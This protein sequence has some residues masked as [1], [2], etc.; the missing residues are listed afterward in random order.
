MTAVPF[1]FIFAGGLD[2]ETPT[3]NK[4]PG[5]AI[6]CLNHE[7]SSTGYK[8]IQGFERVSGRPS[9]AAYDLL[10]GEFE[11][12]AA[13]LKN[14]TIVGLTSGATAYVVDVKTLSGSTGAG[15]AAGLFC[16]DDVTGE[17]SVGEYLMVN[18][19]AIAR[20]AQQPFPR[21]RFEGPD[22]LTFWRAATARRRN[23]I[24]RPP[25]TGPVRGVLWFN[26]Q[27]H[28]WRDK[29]GGASCGMY[30]ATP[31]GWILN[32]TNSTIEF[33]GGGPDSINDG[34]VIVGG[35]SGATATVVR[36]ALEAGS[37]WES[38]DAEGVLI[39]SGITG[40]FIED[41]TLN[42]GTSLGIATV[43]AFTG[44]V[45]LPPGGRYEF[46]VHNFYGS[47]GYERAYGVNGVGKGFEFDGDNIVVI[48]TGMEDDRPFLIAEHKKHLF[49]GFPKGS[50]QNSALGD[51]RNFSAI[52]GAA[53][54][55]MGKELTNL[56]P[57]TADSMI[58][59]TD[60]SISALTGNDISDFMLQPVSPTA[61]AKRF[62]AQNVGNVIYM[63]NRGIRSAASAQVYGNFNLGTYNVQIGKTLETKRNLGAQP[64]ASMTIK[65][66]D[67][68]RLFFD[69]KTGVSFY[70][71]RKV[72]EAM[73][74]EYPFKVTCCHVAEVDGRERIFVG[75]DDG[76]VYE[77]DVGTSYDGQPIQA[78]LQLAYNYV[79]SPRIMK[80]FH[81]IALD[82]EATPGTLISIL[83]QFDNAGDL[84][85]YPHAENLALT[86][87]G[88][89]WAISNWAEFYWDSPD[90]ARAETSNVG[91]GENLSP[92]IV[93][94]SDYMEGYTLQS[95]TIM[96][97]QRGLMR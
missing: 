24:G 73:I 45:Q 37:T 13:T 23:A 82:V 47:V 55:G 7:A 59:M 54:I 92:I 91:S 25:G 93:S 69:D 8:R 26:G 41:E 95:A 28:A 3:L 12:G 83:A 61:G 68:Y 72:P 74:F 32:G 79:R 67:Q 56:I 78:M 39:V 38:G 62:T 36:A 86:G 88:G 94:E 40:T 42:V 87:G 22:F 18:D 84:Q 85:P 17:F 50:L 52:E 81:K 89:I 71:G 21:D 2:Q 70:M 10:V 29:V 96:W 27:L 53:E 44:P 9:P 49:F 11:Q 35:E 60:E 34:D 97:S 77:L 90:V 48:T 46:V 80:R 19:V 6:A 20:L 33:R 57:N 66:K 75:A 4:N 63:D 51:P 64:V 16:A 58:V 30:R 5:R 76:Y 15:T 31:S 65:G 1:P 14:K 43:R